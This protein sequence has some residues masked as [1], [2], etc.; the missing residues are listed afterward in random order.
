MALAQADR[1]AIMGSL[2]FASEMW[3]R[4][5]ARALALIWAGW[6]VLFGVASGIEEKLNPPGILIHSAV[7]GLIFLASVITAWRWESVGGVIL[8][9]EGLFVC[10][11]YPTTM[12]KR[13]PLSTI[14]CVL[15]TMALPP[16][17]AGLLFLVS[18]RKS[19]S[20]DYS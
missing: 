3:M 11:A 12:G 20:K 14:F 15:V 4:Y 7:P 17:I 8:L 2:H 1:R 16:L 6:W 10:I 13:F 9:L 19:R 5:I 18:R